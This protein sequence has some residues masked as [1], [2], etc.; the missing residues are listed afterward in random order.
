MY[1]HTDYYDVCMPFF[2][3]IN[4]FLQD[5]EIVVFINKKTDCENS[6]YKY[7]YYD[8]K[9]SYTERVYSCLD[10]L[11]KEIILFLHEDMILY[12]NI[13]VN[14]IEE[15]IDII[16]TEKADFIKLIKAGENLVKAFD[17]HKNLTYC[18][19]N[20]MFSI[21]PTIC[22]TAKIKKIFENIKD[23]GWGLENKA[24]EICIKNN[25]FKCYMVSSEEDVKRGLYHY[26]SKFFP[27][28]ATAIVKGKWNHS[29]YKDE[30][31]YI[32]K[33]YAINKNIRGTV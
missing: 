30:L 31:D 9:L 4:Q 24:S 21:Q 18:P 7:I 23:T 16:K 22:K 19:P 14:I 3:Q 8:D 25:F 28:I 26:D 15:F 11:D 12:K 13:E 20:N 5:Q 2:G 10:K 6:K 33:H 1:S 32:F 27:Y 17:T 29:E